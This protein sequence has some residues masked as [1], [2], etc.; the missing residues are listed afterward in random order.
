M[1]N[2]LSRKNC[3]KIL[4]KYMNARDYRLSSETVSPAERL[5]VDAIIFLVNEKR[6]AQSDGIKFKRHKNKLYKQLKYVATSL[7]IMPDLNDMDRLITAYG[8][9]IRMEAPVGAVSWFTKGY[10]NE[11]KCEI[12]DYS[13][14]FVRWTQSTRYA[15]GDQHSWGDPQDPDSTTTWSL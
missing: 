1:N 9:R 6:N 12:G 8:V 11:T 10:N 3:M 2:K 7:R 5:L 13:E 14:L 4:S 15:S